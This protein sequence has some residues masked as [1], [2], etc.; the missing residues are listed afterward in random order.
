MALRRTQSLF[1]YAGHS[2]AVYSRNRRMQDAKVSAVA[3]LLR[4]HRQE[5]F[6]NRDICVLDI[7]CGDGAN[8]IRLLGRTPDPWGGSPVLGLCSTVVGVDISHSMVEHCKQ[9]HAKQ[10]VTFCSVDARELVNYFEPDSFDLVISFNSLHWLPREDHPV[11]LAGIQRILRK[12]G[13][14]FL[15]LEGRG[16]MQPIFDSIAAVAQS[17]QWKDKFT[18]DRWRADQGFERFSQWEYERLLQQAGFNA[19]PT[20]AL[21]VLLAV[22]GQTTVLRHVSRHEGLDGVRSRLA[23]A[24]SEMPSIANYLTEG[25]ERE[26]FLEEVALNFTRSSTTEQEILLDNSLLVVEAGAE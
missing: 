18:N 4:R 15:E 13:S 21:A 25:T 10:G 17:E 9:T 5:R 19:V 24:W 11:M 1:G 22:R 2:A 8:L 6:C 12:G 20:G 7:G 14:A 23:G 16:S 3:R 26:T